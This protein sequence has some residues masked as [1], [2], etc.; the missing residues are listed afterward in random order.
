MK[1]QKKLHLTGYFDSNFGDD[2]MMKLVVR[3]LPEITFV[4][5]DKVQTPIL[6]EVNVISQNRDEC[7]LLPKLIVTG[8]GFMINN[9]EALK[10]EVIWFLK[11]RNPG[12]YCLGCNIEPLNTPVKRFLISRKMD[13]FR[14]IT[15]RDQVSHHWLR[16]NTRHPEIHCLP[17]ILFSLPDEW[18]PKVHSPN[19]LGISMMHRA[20]DQED[21]AYY[22]AMA[23]LA[24][25]WIRKTGK[26]VILMAFDTGEENDVFS[27][28]AVK[29]LMEFSNH[30][31]IATHK[32]G[33]EIL[34]A[35]A[36]CEKIIAA[37]FHATVLALRMGIQLYPLIFRDKVRNLLKD[38]QYPYHTC[39]L[40]D[41]DKSSL[42]IFLEE[43]QKPYHVGK[44]IFVRAHQHVQLLKRQY[45]SDEHNEQSKHRS[46]NSV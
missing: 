3:S 18:I 19:K 32:D 37:R 10:T 21:C 26:D 39:D 46:D 27:C 24:D 23:E 6:S 35:F 20:G 12:D 43:D 13:K 11:R 31:E 40:D 4:I 33:T 22:R 25:E 28:Q 9:S 16:K 45:E 29:S 2:L 42:R 36:Q 5:E 41:I 14:L 7:A 8:C 34:A 1:Q 17:D 38:L 30:A 15:C 44:D